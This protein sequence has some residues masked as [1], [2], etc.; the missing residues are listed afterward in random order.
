MA[1]YQNIFTRVQAHAPAY[2]GVPLPYGNK[3]REGPPTQQ[4]PVAIFSAVA[5][6]AFRDHML[7]KGAQDYWTKAAFDFNDLGARIDRLLAAAAA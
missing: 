3:E 1:E 7:V 4:I 6:P 2:V 5:D